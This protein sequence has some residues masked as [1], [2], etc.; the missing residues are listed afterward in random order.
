MLTEGKGDF[1]HG[2]LAV[3]FFQRSRL[4]PTS[5][6]KKDGGSLR[7]FSFGLCF[8]GFMYWWP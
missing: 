4:G 5:K 7:I 2:S 8:F 3:Q 1:S 6:Q